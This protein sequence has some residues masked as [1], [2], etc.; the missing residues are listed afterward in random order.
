[1]EETLK[2]KYMTDRAIDLKERIDDLCFIVFR[3]NPDGAELLQCL[4]D[5]YLNYVSP[6]SGGLRTDALNMA[7]T[8]GSQDMIRELFNHAKKGEEAIKRASM[9]AMKKVGA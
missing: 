5:Y 1:M 7:H 8:V 4:F 9:E 2:S 6:M 3:K